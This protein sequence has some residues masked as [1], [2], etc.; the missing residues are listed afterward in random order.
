ME[1]AL[2]GLPSGDREAAFAAMA[3]NLPAELAANGRP[4]GN[5]VAVAEHA[6]PIDQLV[7]WYGRRP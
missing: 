3:A 2:R 4:F 1:A 5:P 6:T 7:A